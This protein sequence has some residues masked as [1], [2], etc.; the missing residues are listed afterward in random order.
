MIA[1]YQVFITLGILIAYIFDYGL[2]RVT[3][4]ASYRVPIGVQIL[5]GMILAI[6]GFWLPESP[7]YLLAR[8][9][10]D[11]A[12]ATVARVKSSS[13]DD[14]DVVAD[15]KAMQVK[16]D[17]ERTADKSGWLQCF[18]GSPKLGYRT[19]C[20][21]IIQMLQQLTG[22]SKFDHVTK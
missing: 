3:S 12:L 22:A 20:G 15:V 11:D 1:C 18:I 21:M 8:G 5:W 17:E 7:R 16:I 19:V 4:S 14:P 9:R 6:G 13:V 10:Y 2:E